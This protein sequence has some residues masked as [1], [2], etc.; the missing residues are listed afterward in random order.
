MT[1]DERALRL[2]EKREKYTKDKS[3]VFCPKCGSSDIQTFVAT[4][5]A[6]SLE[7]RDLH[8]TAE[9]EEHQCEG[10]GVAFWV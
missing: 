10:C 1:Q 4:W 9:L 5:F 7:K 2:K 8:N 6:H 3:V